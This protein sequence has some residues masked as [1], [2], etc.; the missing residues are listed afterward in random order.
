MTYHFGYFRLNA[1]AVE[2]EMDVCPDGN[3]A[4]NSGYGTYKFNSEYL[5]YGRSLSMP[6]FKPYVKT[7]VT[8][9]LTPI[10]SASLSKSSLCCISAVVPMINGTA[11]TVAYVVLDTKAE[12]SCNPVGDEL[13][14]FFKKSI[15]QFCAFNGKQNKMDT[16]K[17]R[18]FFVFLRMVCGIGIKK[19]FT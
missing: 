19:N 15:S 11:I 7:V 1:V 8:P 17:N 6:Y 16:Q 14:T 4:D 9:K 5:L 18:F 10:Y 3:D 2:N 12:H 13:L